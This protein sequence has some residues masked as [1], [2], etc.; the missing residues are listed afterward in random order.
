MKTKET[1]SYIP[2]T[3]LMQ[4]RPNKTA[5][6]EERAKNLTGAMERTISSAIVPKD[7]PDGTVNSKM[8]VS[9]YSSCVINKTYRVKLV[10]ETIIVRL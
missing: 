1:F 9:Q 7:S 10:C 5:W 2:Q 8:M 3:V 4:K 6:T